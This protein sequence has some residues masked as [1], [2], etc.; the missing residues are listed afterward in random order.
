MYKRNSKK[1]N[2]TESVSNWSKYITWNI[3]QYGNLF[4]LRES[5]EID[6]Q[7]NIDH[8]SMTYLFD[9]NNGEKLDFSN[10]FSNASTEGQFHQ[11]LKRYYEKQK[12]EDI[13]D[14]RKSEYGKENPPTADELADTQPQEAQD[15][16]MPNWWEI[17]KDTLRLTYTQSEMPTS[18]LMADIGVDIPMTE[19]DP[20]L[21]PRYRRK[22]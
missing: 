6:D 8:P 10:L 18:N 7:N 19:I 9:K 20:L 2:P 17:S 15:Y 14:Y 3:F 22:R 4:I 1:E 11:I 12:K 16:T 5:G 13:A 21:K